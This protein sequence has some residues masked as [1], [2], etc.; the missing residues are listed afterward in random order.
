MANIRYLVLSD[1]HL[2]AGDN[3]LTNADGHGDAQPGTA[4]PTLRGLGSALRGLVATLNEGERP[5]LVL[6][7]S[8][9][10]AGRA[11]PTSPSGPR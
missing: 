9:R 8:T 2:G 4:S 7:G 10:S 1:L 11:G 5:T 3:L 6:L